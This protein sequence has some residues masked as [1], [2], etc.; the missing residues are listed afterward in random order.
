[1]CQLMGAIQ[2]VA[3][4]ASTVDYLYTQVHIN[5]AGIVIPDLFAQNGV[6]HIVDEVRPG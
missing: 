6:Y 1:M 5:T 2:S 3:L 4:I